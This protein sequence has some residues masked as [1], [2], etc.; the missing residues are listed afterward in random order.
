METKNASDNVTTTAPTT[1]TNPLDAIR[2]VT[3]TSGDDDPL[4]VTVLSGFLG[5]GKTT[6]L[7]HLVHNTEGIR[8]AMIVNDMADLQ[9]DA[10][11]LKDA[12]QE[13]ERMVSLSNGCICCTLREDL[14]VAVANLASRRHELDCIVIESSGISEPLPVAET[15][16]FVDAN[17][18]SLSRV[19]RLDALV[20]VVDASTVVRELH[21]FE[22]TLADRG[23]DVD[24]D[25]HERTVAQL[26]CDQL[27]FANILVLN[28]LDLLVSDE[29]RGRVTALVRRFNPNAKLIESTYGKVDPPQLLGTNLFSLAEAAQHPDW[30]SLEEHTPE[31]EEY[32]ISSLVFRSRRPFHVERF[33]AVTTLMEDGVKRLLT[34]TTN[35][36]DEDSTTTPE[37]EKKFEQEEEEEASSSFLSESAQ[38]AA[39]SVIRSKGLLW[40]GSQQSHWQQAT[41]SLAGQQFQIT[42]GSPWLAAIHNDSS[43]K[44]PNNNTMDNNNWEAP[45]GDRRTE[46]VVIGQRLNHEAMR[47]AL[48]ACVMTPDEMQEYTQLFLESQ[49]LDIIDESKV[50]DAELREKIRKYKIEVATP[51]EQKTQILKETPKS[52]EAISAHSC[53]AIY[54]GETTNVA[55]FQIQRYLRYAHLLPDLASGLVKELELPLASADSQTALLVEDTMGSLSQ[56]IQHHLTKGDKV[57]L[58][59]L[60]IRVEYDTPV[61]E[62]RY[63]IIQQC[64]K[65]VKLETPEQEQ[66]LLTEYPE[67]Q[68]MIRKDQMNTTC[69]P[70]VAKTRQQQKTGK[71]KGKKGKKNRK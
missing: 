45:W 58:E 12:I 7:Q 10:S 6:L 20:T 24:E 36:D 48:E 39:R 9:V 55:K 4:P 47:E 62:D 35:E 13:E 51:K 37:E 43:S 41:A 33:E 69:S 64:Q 67:P 66:A 70:P 68:I 31:T 29:E 57:E 8:I 19:A 40:L 53:I 23:W 42:F 56:M 65:L 71:K 25:D 2:A 60:Q 38:T 22:E 26:L 54:Q 49:P 18:V 52:T 61:D 59:W 44:P 11:L 32:G 30:L 3:T 50:D 17:G 27:E 5:A 21:A 1:T 46:L 14:F 15:F 28:K 34:T 16:T 63:R